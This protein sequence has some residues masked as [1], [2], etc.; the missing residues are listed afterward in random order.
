MTM[1]LTEPGME[2]EDVFSDVLSDSRHEPGSRAG[3]MRCN[4]T[5]RSLFN[6]QQE[7]GIYSQKRDGWRNVLW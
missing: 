5:G 3:L 6:G 4:S 7:I 2:T 1:H